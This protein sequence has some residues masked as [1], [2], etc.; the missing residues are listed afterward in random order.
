[1]GEH[2]TSVSD[3]EQKHGYSA[4]NLDNV[5]AI[6]K[7]ASPVSFSVRVSPICLPSA[8][9]NYDN[10][11]ATVTGWGTLGISAGDEPNILQKVLLTFLS[12]SGPGRVKVR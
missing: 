12:S 4:C 3:G 6:I 7:P 10:K 1:M 11:V 2:D 9:T 8:S 5:F